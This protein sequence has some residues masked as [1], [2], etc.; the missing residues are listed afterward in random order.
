MKT[1]ILLINLGTPDAPK[2]GAVGRYLREFL[3][4]ERVIDIPWLP[5]KLLVHGIIAPIRSFRSAREYK[6]VWT[7]EVA[8]AHSRRKGPGSAADPHEPP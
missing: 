2:P 5:R 4:D 7:D 3:G 8:L 1:G 6:K